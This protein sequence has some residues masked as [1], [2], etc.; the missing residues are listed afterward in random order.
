MP[1]EPHLTIAPDP[2]RRTEAADR[3]APRPPAPRHGRRP[4]H[5]PAAA[6]RVHTVAGTFVSLKRGG[7]LRSCCGLL[8]TPTPLAQALEQAAYRTAWEDVRFPPVSP[9][10][11]DHLDLEV[12]LLYDPQPVPACGEE[13]LQAV[14]VG[15]HGI[16][17][18]RGDARGLFLP[19]VAV[20][21]G[22]DAR[23]FLDQVCVKA[24]LPPTAWR[25]DATAL[26]TFEG[27]ALLRH[28]PG[29]GSRSPAGPPHAGP[30]HLTALCR[31]LPRQP[32]RSA[33]R[34]HAQLLSL[35]HPTAT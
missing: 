16:Q 18:V 22:W 28:D 25:D 7:H 29:A 35:V 19:S 4:S 12:W 32:G 30:E 17:V 8:G 21:N 13:R 23:R 24:G 11:L 20:D 5:C 33:D 2:D 14:T 6:V 31:L 27:E 15:Q 9:A 3:R 10:E 1:T 34:S 26:F